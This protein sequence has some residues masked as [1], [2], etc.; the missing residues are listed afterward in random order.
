VSGTSKIMRDAMRVGKIC[1]EGS[2]ELHAW[3]LP[4]CLDIGICSVLVSEKTERWAHFDD[5]NNR[6][7]VTFGQHKELRK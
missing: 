4:T 3:V 6:N 7:I 1:A 5:V 2:D